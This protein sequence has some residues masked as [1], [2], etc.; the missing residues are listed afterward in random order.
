MNTFSKIAVLSVLP[1]I[2]SVATAADVPN[3]AERAA[4]EYLNLAKY[5]EWTLPV[6]AGAPNPILSE[7]APDVVT[8][9]GPNGAG[10]ALSVWAGEIRYQRGDAVE[11]FAQLES[12]ASNDADI[13]TTPSADAKGP[14]AVSGEVVNQNGDTLVSLSFADDGKGA[15]ETAGD[16]I[17]S[18]S[19]TLGEAGQPAVGQ[20]T[21]LGFRVTAEND[22][23]EQRVA[24]NGF[25]YSHPAATLTGKFTDRIVDGNLVIAAQVDVVK[26]G[27]VHLSGVIDNPLG[28][29]LVIAQTS[30]V[31][32]EGEQWIELP[33][34]G[35]PLREA[36]V[37]GALSLGAVTL[38]TT[39]GMPNALGEVLV[40]AHSTKAVLPAVFTDK[41]FGRGALLE[42]A[43]RL[44]AI[45]Q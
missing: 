22:A 8:R 7:R 37:V 42:A 11:L 40:D 10:P 32:T 19:Y 9:P 43:A 38:T 23:Q 36:G 29:S 33:V 31:L 21:S 44:N 26:A 45:G 4:A 2:S 17:Y 18:A 39:Q 15:D 16:G 28:E 30:T 13:L 14:W 24:M 34:Y 41:P 35:L 25:Q 12:R 3:L 20:A 6:P 5:P 27:R 1:F